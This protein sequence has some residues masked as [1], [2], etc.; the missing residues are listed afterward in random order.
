ME[1]DDGQCGVTKVQFDYKSFC[2]V[3]AIYS[4]FCFLPEFQHEKFNKYN[5]GE[6]FNC[7]KYSKA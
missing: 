6:T 5:K 1:N 7:Q 2:G 4:T 3:I